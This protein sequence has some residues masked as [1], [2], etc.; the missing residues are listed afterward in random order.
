MNIRI[1]VTLYTAAATDRRNVFKFAVRTSIGAWRSCRTMMNQAGATPS[2][3]TIG[4]GPTRRPSTGRVR[5]HGRGVSHSTTRQRRWSLADSEQEFQILPLQIIFLT[6]VITILTL[7][8][9]P[10]QACIA[11][12]SLCTSLS[13]IASL[14]P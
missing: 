2:I 13:H 12:L 6:L 14:H 11:V 9:R 5:R 4:A 8:T 10:R 7:Q 1:P 3:T